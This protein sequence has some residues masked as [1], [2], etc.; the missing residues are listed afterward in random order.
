MIKG[1]INVMIIH[2]MVGLWIIKRMDMGNW[3]YIRRLLIKRLGGIKVWRY[4][5]RRLGLMGIG[6]M[7]RSIINYDIFYLLFFII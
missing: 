7:I 5:G 4:L 3:C 1:V 2:I 6:L